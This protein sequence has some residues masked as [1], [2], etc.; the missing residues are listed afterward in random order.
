MKGSELIIEAN[1]GV[2][3]SRDGTKGHDSS[4]ISASGI[5]NWRGSK[6][7]RVLPA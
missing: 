5:E 2:I 4:H 6:S 1:V 3:F 7:P